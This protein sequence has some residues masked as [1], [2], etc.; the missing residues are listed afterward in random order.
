M[1]EKIFWVSSCRY[2]LCSHASKPIRLPQCICSRGISL[3][4]KAYE[5]FFRTKGIPGNF[6]GIF[7]KTIGFSGKV[8]EIFREWFAPRLY[9]GFLL[10]S[11]DRA[12]CHQ[13]LDQKEAVT[14]YPY[15]NLPLPPSPT[16]TTCSWDKTSNSPIS[17]LSSLSRHPSVM[18]VVY[19]AN[20]RHFFSYDISA[21]AFLVRWSKIK[22]CYLSE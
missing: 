17:K 4:L 19:Q 5:I 1:F 10:I 16:T 6:L 21:G 22:L 3:S 2:L 8:Y 15:D 13:Y 7:I 14:T 20:S 12:C 9:V 18:R 11:I